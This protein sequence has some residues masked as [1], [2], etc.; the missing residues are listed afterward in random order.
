MNAKNISARY[1]AALLAV[2][3]YSILSAQ[4]A[5]AGTSEDAV[6]KVQEQAEAASEL[7]RERRFFVMPIPISNP[8][9][10][11]GLGASATYLFDAGENAPTSSLNLMG[12]YTDT[13]TWAVG[14]GTEIYFKDDKYRLSGAVGYFDANLEFYGIGSGAGDRG[15]SIGINQKGPF[16]VPR[17]LIQVSE[18]FYLG[19]QFRYLAIDTSLQ[20]PIL[21]PDFPPG[22]VPTSIENVTSGL[23]VVLERDTRDNKYFPYQGSQLIATTNFAREWVGSD[24]NYEQFELGYNLYRKLGKHGV[25]AWRATGCFREGNVPFYDLCNFGGEEDAIRGYV[26]GQY[27]DK[28]SITTQVEF[29]WQL[30]KKWGMVAFGGVGQ[31]APQIDDIKLDDLLPSVGVG[32]RWMASEKERVNLSIDYAKGKDSSA[33]YFRIGEA[34]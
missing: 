2:L 14:L 23:G 16:L 17:F 28:V 8:T 15:E 5:T 13:D 18:N 1:L 34:F 26:G 22:I 11:T 27:R 21:P 32:I 9:I 3:I 4:F 30:Y 6:G 24:N 31:V 20:V 29:R 19:P 33:W 25:L 10:G 7:L 12:L